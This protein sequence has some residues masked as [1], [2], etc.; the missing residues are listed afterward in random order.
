MSTKTFRADNKRLRNTDL[1][2]I[3]FNEVF[4]FLSFFAEFLFASHETPCQQ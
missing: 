2:P 1:G 3:S 4:T